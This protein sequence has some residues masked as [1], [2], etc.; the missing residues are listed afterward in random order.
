M[1]FFWTVQ[2][3]LKTFSFLKSEKE[4]LETKK[5]LVRMHFISL[6]APSTHKESNKIRNSLKNRI[7]LHSFLNTIF[8]FARETIESKRSFW[9][10]KGRSHVIS[11]FNC[12]NNGL[13]I[14]VLVFIKQFNLNEKTILFLN[15]YQYY[16]ASFDVEL[17]NINRRLYRMRSVVHCSFLNQYCRMN[18]VWT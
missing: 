3:Y 5:F 17:I 15:F 14:L 10:K 9:T 8:F 11:L 12:F 13:W 18:A 2:N 4:T 1:Q 7:E 16:F 6:K